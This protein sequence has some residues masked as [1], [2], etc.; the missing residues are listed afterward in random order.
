[1]A[2]IGGG[3]DLHSSGTSTASVPHERK[4]KKKKRK[5]KKK[6]KKRK[7]EKKKVKEKKERKKRK[8]EKKGKGKRG[9]KKKKKKGD[10]RCEFPPLRSVTA[11]CRDDQ[12]RDHVGQSVETRE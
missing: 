11:E 8:K 1:M 2:R 5:K 12:R 10:N 4:Q 7:K 3:E 9:K 6:G